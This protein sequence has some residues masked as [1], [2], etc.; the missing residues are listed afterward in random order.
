[1][2]ELFF[3]RRVSLMGILAAR[4]ESSTDDG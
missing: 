4:A 3:I 2:I 1:M